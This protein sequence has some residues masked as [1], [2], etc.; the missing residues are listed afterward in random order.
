MP[1]KQSRAAIE[2]EASVQA[3]IDSYLAGKHKSITKA[4]HAFNAPLS[5]VK[6]CFKGRPHAAMGVKHKRHCLGRK[7]VN[8]HIGLHILQPL[9]IHLGFNRSRKWQ[10]KSGVNASE[11]LMTMGL[12]VYITHHLAKNGS[13]VLLIVT[14]T[15]NP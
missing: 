15:W 10:K 2:K 5:T 9:D 4:A 6:H 7:K 3:A 1:R 12:N 11:K 8:W 14:Q 13:R